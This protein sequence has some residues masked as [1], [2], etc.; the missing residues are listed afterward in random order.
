VLAMNREIDK[1]L[2]LMWTTETLERMTE[3]GFARRIVGADGQVRYQLTERGRTVSEQ[4]FE[5]AMSS[6]KPE[7]NA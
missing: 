1:E 6:S 4:E 5:A 2:T 7:G 3:L